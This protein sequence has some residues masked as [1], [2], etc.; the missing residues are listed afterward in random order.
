MAIIYVRLPHYVASYLRNVDRDN[1]ITKGKP[2]VIE[3]GDPLYNEIVYSAEPNTRCDINIDCFS[4]KQWEAMAK[5]KYLYFR[6][7]E[8]RLDLPR[9]ATDPLT[10]G[11]IFTLSGSDDRV[12]R[13]LITMELLPDSEYVDEYVPFLL[14]RFIVRGGREVKVYSDWYLPRASRFRNELISRFDMGL[15]R[16]IA[17]DRRAARA[18]DIIDRERVLSPR[19]QIISKMES[20]DHF[21]LEYDIRAGDREREQIK[22][23]LQRS[24]KS[25]LYAFDADIKHARLNVPSR[26]GERTAIPIFCYDNGETYSSISAFA[27]AIGATP[28]SAIMALHRGT[29]CHGVRFERADK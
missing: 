9:N 14:P 22:K 26:R 3:T 16:Y 24:N 12:K 13:D 4:Q 27:R 8:F 15:M 21:M 29:R 17:N 19:H 10:L 11:E 18:L 2:I 28:M 1:P 25:T 20:I 23:R 7:G 6:E 5:G